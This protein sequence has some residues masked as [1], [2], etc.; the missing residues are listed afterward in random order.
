MTKQTR[1]YR[2]VA[3]SWLFALLVPPVLL[4]ATPSEAQEIRYSWLDLSYMSQ[5]VGRQGSQVPI[6]G[7]TVDVDA[8]NGSGVRF[9]GSF[10]T[11]HNLYVF[12][13]YASTDIDVD[14]VVTNDQGVFPASDQFDLTTIRGGAG[15]KYSVGFN[16]DIFLEASYDSI[17]LDFGSFAGENFDTNDQ[18]F[19]ATLGVRSLLTDDLELR[20]WGRY[21]NHADVDL[22]T[23]QFDTGAAYGAGF[24][25]QIV[26]GLH[27]VADYEAGEFDN[28]SIGFRL[29]LDED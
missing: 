9:R 22:N 10:G 29:D 13:S 15:A 14:A 2:R 26:R 7:Q 12:I 28:W 20:A 25:W 1:T 8:G 17:D 21:S 27:I 6:A 5:D 4:V 3:R 23:L 16:T 19:G 24:G 11:W 18:D